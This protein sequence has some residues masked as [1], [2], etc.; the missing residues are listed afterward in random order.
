M[1]NVHVPKVSAEWSPDGR[2]LMTATTSP[3]LNVD[4]GFK[5]WRYNGELLQHVE[6]EKLFEAKWQPANKSAYTDRPISAGSVRRDISGFGNCDEPGSKKT[7][8]Y[9]LPKPLLMKKD[10]GNIDSRTLQPNLP[11]LKARIMDRQ[12]HIL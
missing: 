3:R 11:V 7:T 2:S 12:G 4:N 10:Q 9:R 8:P 6:R 5:L 1:W